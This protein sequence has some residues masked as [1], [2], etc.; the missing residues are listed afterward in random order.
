MPAEP[1]KSRA[2][3]LAACFVFG[4]VLLPLLYILSIGPA[5]WLI[6]HG[7]LSDAAARWFYTPLGI[8]AERSEF[9]TAWLLRYMQLFQS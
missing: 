2:G 5:L 7:Y 1:E 6:E 8:V 3:P 9:L 4:L